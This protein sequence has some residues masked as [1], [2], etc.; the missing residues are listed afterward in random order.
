MRFHRL[1]AGARFEYKGVCYR[2]INNLT[3]SPEQGGK[4]TII[5]RSAVVMPADTTTDAAPLRPAP[6]QQLAA[7]LLAELYQHCLGGLAQ[8]SDAAEARRLSARV[9]EQRSTASH[10][11]RATTESAC[12]R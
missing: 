4:N 3:A 5:P 2:K 11:K 6:G 7:E 10:G 1:P 8:L 12:R 9:Q